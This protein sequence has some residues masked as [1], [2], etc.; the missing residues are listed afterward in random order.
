M[1][2]STSKPDDLALAESRFQNHVR[3]CLACNWA[4]CGPELREPRM[5]CF[6]GRTLWEAVTAA[7]WRG[8]LPPPPVPMSDVTAVRRRLQPTA[9][10]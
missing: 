9:R 7:F 3:M 10:R 8:L 1:A 5:L 2:A 6:E 4:V